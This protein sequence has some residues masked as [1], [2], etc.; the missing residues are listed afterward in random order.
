MKTDTHFW[1][2]LSQFFLEW[3]MFRT[4]FVEKI[5][6]HILCSVTFIW[7]SCSLF[8]NVENYCRAGLAI[9]NRMAHA[10]CMLDTLGYKHTVRI[11]NTYFFNCNNGCTPVPQCYVIRTLTV[12]LYISCRGFV[13]GYKHSQLFQE[14]A[15][16]SPRPKTL[17]NIWVNPIDIRDIRYNWPRMRMNAHRVSNKSHS[18]PVLKFKQNYLYRIYFVK[19]PSKALEAYVFHSLNQCNRRPS[20]VTLTKIL[21]TLKYLKPIGRAIIEVVPWHLPGGPEKNH[22]IPQ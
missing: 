14:S 18:P 2:Y 10:H 22:A 6:T 19:Q 5:K 15:E 17:S 21:W 1:S 11:C 13:L 20:E 12:L 7:K 16:Y 3:E 4:K 9:D 8:D